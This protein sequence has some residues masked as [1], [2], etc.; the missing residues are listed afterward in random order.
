M[1]RPHLQEAALVESLGEPF[2]AAILLNLYMAV[3][4]HGGLLL[5]TSQDCIV[6]SWLLQQITIF[7]VERF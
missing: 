4:H 7:M 2:E 6:R 3:A 1:R 5:E